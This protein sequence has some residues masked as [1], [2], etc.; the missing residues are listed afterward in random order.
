MNDSERYRS[1]ETSGPPPE[2]LI[3][4]LA[5][6]KTFDEGVIE[7]VTRLYIPFHK[8]SDRKAAKLTK[9]IA[10]GPDSRHRLDVHEP[11][12]RPENPIPIVGYFHG[13]GFVSGD[14]NVVGDLI[15]GNI[16]NYFA[17]N[18]MLGINAT[19]RLAPRHKWPEG[20]KDVAGVVTWLKE[21]GTKY[22]GDPN[23]IF[24]FGHSAG[25][26]HVAT[27]LFHRELQPGGGA[28]IA[29]AILMSGQYDPDPKQPGPFDKAY[30][31]TDTEKYAEMAAIN[32]IDGLEVPVFIVFAEFDTHQ[33]EMQ[34]VKLFEALCERDKHCPRLTRI[35]NHNHIS[36]A[37]HINTEDASIGPEI[38]DFIKTGR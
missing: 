29:G 10:Y 23:R 2:V 34:S 5:M 13:G 30:Y 32:H 1:E 35:K 31:G 3:E 37:L 27:Y 7:K 38:I 8:K 6:G 24:L 14:K 4:I 19:Y 15:Y 26:A 12:S 22:G 20:A 11:H 25:A 36:E 21:S 9:D 33:I 28:G 16:G 17:R 18:G